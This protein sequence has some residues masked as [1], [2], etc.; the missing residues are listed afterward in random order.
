[1]RAPRALGIAAVGLCRTWSLAG[2]V[3]P[4]RLQSLARK[5][6]NRGVDITKARTVLGFEPL[7][8]VEGVDRTLARLEHKGTA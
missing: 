4:T 3:P 5:V 7:P 1:V 8:L 6:T 2:R